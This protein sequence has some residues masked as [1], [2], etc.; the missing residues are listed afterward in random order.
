VAERIWNPREKKHRDCFIANVLAPLIAATRPTELRTE[1]AVEDA[2]RAWILSL[3]EVPAEVLEAGVAR[4]LET[5]TSWMPRPAD[6]RI[7]CAAVVA[8]RHKAL[9]PKAAEIVAECLQCMGTTWETVKG[10]DGI[11]RVK[12]CG[13]KARVLALYEGLPEP[14]ALPPAP[15]DAA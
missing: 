14:I 15:E 7:A 10:E 8:E 1:Q 12:R 5:G 9:A 4:L 2:A 3:P 6:L 11:E 13:C